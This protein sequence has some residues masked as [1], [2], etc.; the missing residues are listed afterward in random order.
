M[1]ATL[2]GA[3]VLLVPAALSAQRREVVVDSASVASVLSAVRGAS[4]VLCELAARSVEQH[5]GW[6]GWGGGVGPWSI[7]APRDGGVRAAI[8]AINSEKLPA[9]VIPLLAQSLGDADACVRRVA[10]PMLGRIDLPAALQALRAAL[11][12]DQAATREAAA[13]G[14]GYSENAAAIPALL[15]G[16]QDSVARVRVACALALGEIEDRRA[17]GALVRVLREDR[18]E[19]VRAAAAWA[20]GEIEG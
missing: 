19:D 5:W 20:L 13:I 2:L 3:A 11:R 9:S 4:P 15:A 16:L 12:D 10:A 7:R 17:I 8:E 18:D 1:R 6:G 14:M